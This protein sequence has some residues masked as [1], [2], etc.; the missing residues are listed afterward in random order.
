LIGNDALVFILKMNNTGFPSSKFHRDKCWYCLI[1]AVISV[2]IPFKLVN[3]QIPN[4]E[5][6]QTPAFQPTS[7]PGKPPSIQPLPELPL[8]AELP[9]L[10]ELLL[11]P[12]TSPLP[13]QIPLGENSQT[14]IVKKFEVTGST[15]FRQE[16]FGKITASYINR[17]ITLKDLFQLR[18]EITNLYLRNEYI[19]SG[20]YIP[21]QKHQD[22]IVEIRIVEGG[23]EDIKVTGT[24]RLNPRY[25]RSCLAIAT[26]KPLKRDRLLEALQLLQLNPLTHIPHFIL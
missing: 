18:S 7:R 14:I 1:P 20:A 5:S 19:T 12:A 25:V 26:N 4:R 13:D 6:A 15:V 21:P 23:L 3:A 11:P 17:P 9:P 24:R 10:Q 8:P 22:G 16:D 2:T